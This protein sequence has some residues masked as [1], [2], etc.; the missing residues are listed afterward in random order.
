M[1]CKESNKQTNTKLI[2]KFIVLTNVKMPTIVGILSFIRKINTLSEYLKA[3]KIIIFQD[4]S[5]Y[6]QLKFHAELGRA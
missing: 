4:F 2:M 6:E 3:R 1:G 5:F